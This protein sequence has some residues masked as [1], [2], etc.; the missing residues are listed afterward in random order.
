MKRKIYEKLLD[1]K[2]NSKGK[3]AILID[4]ARRVGKS[5]IAEE[6]AKNNYKSYI[7]IDFYKA[8]D[9][10]KDLFNIYLDDLDKLFLYLSNY[11]DVELYERE[12]LFIFDEIQF[13]PRARA[14]IKYLVAD[15]RYD[16]IETGSLVSIK[17]NVQDILIPSEEE[18]LK[19]YPMDFEEFLWAMGDEKS[20]DFMR[21]CFENNKPMGEVMHRKVMDFF[22]LYMIIGGMPQVVSE[23][24]TTKDFKAVDKAK[25][26]ILTMYRN[27]IRQHAKKYSLKAENVFDN[28]PSQ[29]QKHEKKFKITSLDKDARN[30][31]YDDVFMWLDDAMIVNRAFNTTEP[32]IGLSLNSDDSTMK[33]F[34]ADTGLLISHSFDENGITEEEIYK[35]ILF[36][37][38]EFN[39][40]MLLE[41]MV[42]QMLVANNHK[43]FFFS[44]PSRDEKNDRMEIDFLIQKRNIT[45]RHNIS[46]LEVKS[47]KNY[48]TNSLS[49]FINKYKNNLDKAYVIH[50]NDFKI[51]NDIIYLPIYMLIFL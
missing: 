16:Y 21:M 50:T 39:G 6:F 31:D 20:V 28:I 25:R 10:I 30:R 15:H 12:T 19:L 32:S 3:T 45:N 22:R 2:E 51:E 48:T 5:Y 4:G 8:P 29:L 44:K 27:D 17:E 26:T 7:L 23:Y 14:A 24:I 41:N 11:Y 40:G 33:C 46:P 1:W 13:F 47:G 43:L 36:N 49:K 34:M 18:H 38:L 35:K 37:K 42:S 9:E